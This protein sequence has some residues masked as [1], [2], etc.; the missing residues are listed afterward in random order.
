MERRNKKNM[1]A[2]LYEFIILVL[3]SFMIVFYLNLH[4]YMTIFWKYTLERGDSPLLDDDEEEER[5]DWS[6]CPRVQVYC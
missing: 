6:S 5:R 3:Y 2:Q 1:F 4:V